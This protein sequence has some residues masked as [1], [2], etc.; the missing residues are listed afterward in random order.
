ME[1]IEKKYYNKTILNY[2]K[3]IDKFM[4]NNN[5]EININ[6]NKKYIKKI[7][8]LNEKKINRKYIKFYYKANESHLNCVNTLISYIIQLEKYKE[9]DNMLYDDNVTYILNY[10]FEL[11]YSKNWKKYINDFDINDITKSRKKIELYNIFINRLIKFNYTVINFEKKYKHKLEKYNQNIHHFD[12]DFY[13][14]IINLYIQLS[15][16][17][18]LY[19]EFLSKLSKNN[20]EIFLNYSKYYFIT[21]IT[22]NYDIKM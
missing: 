5:I 8:L 6:K 20:K 19:Y 10:Y 12:N 18:I 16:I 1:Y 17:I 7:L 21:N 11:I 14:K 22:I 3:N 15:N 4:N 13:C 2:D 9:Y